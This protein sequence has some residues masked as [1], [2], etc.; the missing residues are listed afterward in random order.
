MR[1]WTMWLNFVKDKK[2]IL[3]IIFIFI[4]IYRGSVYR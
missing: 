2:A 3:T 1:W 4:F